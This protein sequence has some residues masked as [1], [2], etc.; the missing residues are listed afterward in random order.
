MKWAVPLL[1]LLIVPLLFNS[2]PLEILRL[3][4]F[5]TFVETP[6]PTGFFTI[7]NIEEEYIDE[8]GGYPLPR[9]DLAEIHE[10]LLSKGAIGVGWV[11][12]FPH[13]DRMNGDEIFAKAL[14][15]SPS[16]IAMPEVDNGLYP[17]THGTVIKGPLIEIN[18]A[19]GFLENIDCLLYTSPSPRDRG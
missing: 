14:A 3:K 12:L 19:P 8:K 11:M 16:V 9:Q 17:K 7:L 2:V 18:K 15:S 5:D 1:A 6:E 13:P 10:D 4:T